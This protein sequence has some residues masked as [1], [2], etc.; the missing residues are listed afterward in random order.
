MITAKINAPIERFISTASKYPLFNVFSPLRLSL[1]N[2]Q[3][4]V[5]LLTS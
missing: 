4:V 5:M 2:L 3:A 1:Q